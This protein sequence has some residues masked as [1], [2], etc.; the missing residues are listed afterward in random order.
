[1]HP[2]HVLLIFV[3]VDMAQNVGGYEVER[4]IV[5]VEAGMVCA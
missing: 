4:T 2:R 5:K 1:M 3:L